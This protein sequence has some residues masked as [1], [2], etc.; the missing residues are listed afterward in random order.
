MDGQNLPSFMT[1][2]QNSA[3]QDAIR[4][5]GECRLFQFCPPEDIAKFA[6]CTRLRRHESQAS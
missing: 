6:E 2:A 4:G 3:G 5:L 1:T